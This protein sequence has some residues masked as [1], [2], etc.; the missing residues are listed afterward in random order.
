MRY[1]LLI[2]AIDP[3]THHAKMTKEDGQK[4]AAAYMKYTDELKKAGILL[5]SEALH[6][7]DRNAARVTASG[8]K[9]SVIDGPFSEAKELVGGYYVIQVKSKDE[10]I[11]WAA[12]C[13]GAHYPDWAYVEVR[14]V[15][16][17]G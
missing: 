7:D 4:L 5:S 9:R 14:E 12:R 8:G 3:K 6:F 17:F 15:M 1:M 11:E 10:A 16:E 2:T 13:P